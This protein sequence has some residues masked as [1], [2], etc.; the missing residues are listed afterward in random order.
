MSDTTIDET[1]MIETVMVEAGIITATDM[2]VFPPSAIIGGG[3][4]NV[5]S[6]HIQIGVDRDIGTTNATIRDGILE[7]RNV[8]NR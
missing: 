4:T 6:I 1:S 3:M 7:E 8:R 2:I 5:E